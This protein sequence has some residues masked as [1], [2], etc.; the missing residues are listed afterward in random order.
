MPSKAGLRMLERVFC[1]EIEGLLPFQTKAKLAESLAESGYL[2]PTMKRVGNGP[3]AAT[4][5]GYA[6]THL[7]R[8]TYCGTCDGRSLQAKEGSVATFILPPRSIVVDT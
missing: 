3:F 6:L 8:L 7:G 5:K 2:E 4:V 1:A